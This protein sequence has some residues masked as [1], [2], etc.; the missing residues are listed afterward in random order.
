MIKRRKV[1]KLS[2]GLLA[3]H[4]IGLRA[5]DEKPLRPLITRPCKKSP[6]SIAGCSSSSLIKPYRYRSYENVAQRSTLRAQDTIM[7]Y[8]IWV[9]YKTL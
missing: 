2:A 1:I 3:A 4:S 9:I 8:K 5:S 6:S 7:R